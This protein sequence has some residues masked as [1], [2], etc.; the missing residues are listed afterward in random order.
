MI[1]LIVVVVI[2]VLIISKRED[3]VENVGKILGLLALGGFVLM[4]VLL[5][6]GKVGD[7]F[8]WY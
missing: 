3:K 1:L 8:T 7:S 5:L 4:V 6:I 2:A